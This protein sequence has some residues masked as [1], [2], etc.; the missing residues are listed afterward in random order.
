MEFRITLCDNS[1][2]KV[3][4]KEQARKMGK[5]ARSTY[6]NAARQ[7]GKADLSSG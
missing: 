6:G 5:I 4:H 2:E 1:T 7:V 3:K